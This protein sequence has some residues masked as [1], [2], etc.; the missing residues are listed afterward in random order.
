MPIEELAMAPVRL[1]LWIVLSFSLAAQACAQAWPAK[2]IRL[3]VNF[4]PGGGTDVIARTYAPSLGEALGQPVIVDNVAGARGSIGLEAVARAAPNGY[5]LL[6]TPGNNIIVAPHLYKMP[7]DVEKALEPIAPVA[8]TK[9]LLVVNPS[10]PVHTVAELVKYAKAHPGKLN[11]GSAGVGTLPHIASEMFMRVGQFRAIHVPYKGVGP[12]LTALLGNQIQFTFDSGVSI[13]QIKSGKL[14]LLAIAGDTR[15][16]A[17]PDVPTMAEA[18]Y[19]VDGSLPQGL[20]AP[21]G[22]PKDIVN[23]LHRELERVLQTPAVKAALAKIGAEPVMSASPET[24]AA[25]QKR[26]RERFGV[27]VREAHIRVD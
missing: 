5:T 8:Q 1:I 3:V 13:P 18:G 7:V 6:H 22:T 17:F 21:G 24:F 12:V 27:I 9:I 15:S 23:R 20:Y 10:V 16:A 4:S 11:F 2:P 26:D 25:Q 14:R 19:D